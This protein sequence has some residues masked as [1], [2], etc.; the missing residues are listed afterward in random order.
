M[1]ARKP[2]D[3]FRTNS[4]LSDWLTAASPA[5][6]TAIITE[7]LDRAR[8]LSVLHEVTGLPIPEAWHF[9]GSQIAHA[10]HD[11]R[12]FSEAAHGEY[13]VRAIPRENKKDVI[14]NRN[15]PVSEL[16][17]WLQ[18]RVGDIEK[19][20][21]DLPH[22]TN[23]WATSFAVT[24]S[25]IIAEVV[26]GSLR[27]LTQ[28]EH[29]ANGPV[30][31]V[32]D[33]GT[34]SSDQSDSKAMELAKTAISYSEVSSHEDRERLGKSWDANS[35]MRNSYEDTSKPSSVRETRSGSSTLTCRSE[36]LSKNLTW[37]SF[38]ASR[39]T[40]PGNFEG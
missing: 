28:G 32:Y 3:Y 10:D 25:G 23:E 27:Q 18:G 29:L 30:R 4:A 15:L 7:D 36:H 9:S 21:L 8:R 38:E 16:V 19:Y 24:R 12:E 14:R 35:R 5:S 13:A 37:K 31:I 40:L 2:C 1:S 22:L 26:R 33:Y 11:F 39:K 17:R 34:W 20:D 6:R